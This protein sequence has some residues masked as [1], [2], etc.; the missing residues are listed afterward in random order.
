M[1]RSDGALSVSP[2]SVSNWRARFAE[3]GVA[4]L[5]EVRKGRGS[6]ASIPQETIEKIP[7][8][9]QNYRPEGETHWSC[10]TMADAVGVSKDTVQRV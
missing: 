7:D 9:T 4:R 6:K 2:G 10:R 5:G 3:D 1:P 8:L